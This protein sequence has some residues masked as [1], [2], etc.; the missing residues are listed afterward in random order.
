M[1]LQQ[2]RNV[3]YSRV[4]YSSV[5]FSFLLFLHVFPSY[6]NF[7]LWPTHFPWEAIFLVN[8]QHF[9]RIVWATWAQR[10]PSA[11]RAIQPLP[12]DCAHKLLTVGAPRIWMIIYYTST[13]SRTQGT[14][15]PKREEA[16]SICGTLYQTPP[17]LHLLPDCYCS[18]ID[19]NKHQCDGHWVKWWAI[20]TSHETL[21]DVQT[22]LCAI[23]FPR[24]HFDRHG[25]E[26]MHWTQSA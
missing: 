16:W 25:A 26:I 23:N 9:S 7:F 6:T 4:Q 2:S 13:S 14:M 1:C 10:H 3:P 22:P 18:Y 19:G 20:K 17:M 12:P 15:T 5:Y 24:V 21:G 8:L 11:P